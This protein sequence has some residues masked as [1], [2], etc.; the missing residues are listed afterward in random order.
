MRVSGKAQS[1]RKGVRR[2]AAS[3]QRQEWGQQPE[4]S[5]AEHRSVPRFWTSPVMEAGIGRRGRGWVPRDGRHQS[6]HPRGV[7][8]APR[9]AG[10]AHLFQTGYQHFNHGEGPPNLLNCTSPKI[11]SR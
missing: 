9:G 4:S 6:R 10:S 7:G 5:K 11:K 8:G 2:G 1:H 3:E